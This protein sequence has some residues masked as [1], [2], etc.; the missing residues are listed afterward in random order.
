[1]TLLD[2]FLNDLAPGD[3][4]IASWDDVL[5][6]AA[7]IDPLG[8]ERPRRSRPRIAALV[9]AILAVALIPFVAVAASNGWWFLKYGSPDSRPSKNPVVVKHGSFGGKK[10]Q[11]IAY[12]AAD[13]LCWSLTFIVHANTGRGSAL[14]CGPVAGFASHHPNPEMKIT[15]LASGGGDSYPAWIAGTVV[16]TATTVKLR[17]NTQTI[18]TETFQAPAALGDVR[19][20]ALEA[21]AARPLK[22]G[23][24]PHSPLTWVAG[25]D[26]HGKIVACL[27]PRTARDGVSPFSA[28]R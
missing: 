9:L 22:P 5:T 19:F 20:Y 15:Y 24:R 1:M 12:P 17:V 14:A 23:Q 28:C 21:R 27:N 26:S 7:A 3:G 25:Y 11:L 16:Q 18:T 2:G 6:R 10:W 8:A 4:W 13:G